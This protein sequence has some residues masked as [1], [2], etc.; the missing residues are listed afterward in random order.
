MLLVALFA[1]MLTAFDPYE[2]NLNEA[3]RAPGGIHFLGTDRYGRD[4]LSR[5]I[6]GART[7][8]FSSLGLVL[9][10]C[11]TGSAA[12]IFSGLAGGKIDMVIMGIADLFLAF[13]GMVFAIAVAGVMGG[14][15]MNAVIA[16]AAVSWPKYARLVRVEVL[17]I[18]NMPYMA[19]AR[20]TG[21]SRRQIIGSYI[22]PNLL[23]LVLVTAMLDVGTMMMEISGMSFLGLGAQPPTAEWGSM[24]S[25]GR[26]MIQTAPWVIL[27]PG[28]A[29][30]VSVM[31]FNL[32]GDAVRDVLSPRG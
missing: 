1:P 13:P 21:C 18:R 24:M 15:I 16:L 23:E 20:F 14:G 19:A 10:V 3:L 22:L 12:G 11:T 31:I 5:V 26:S 8:V 17:S 2:H 25:N 30:F 27:A 9:L 28:A 32:W 6:L 4:M 7:S 29:I